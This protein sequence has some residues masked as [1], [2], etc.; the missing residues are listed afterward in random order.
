[1]LWL[2]AYLLPRIITSVMLLEVDEVWYQLPLASAPPPAPSP[3]YEG[4]DPDSCGWPCSGPPESS[5]H[6][7]YASR[8][9][10][11]RFLFVHR[12]P[13]SPYVMEGEDDRHR[14]LSRIFAPAKCLSC[15]ASRH[16]RAGVTE[17]PVIAPCSN[18][19]EK[20]RRA[21]MTLSQSPSDGWNLPR[22]VRTGERLG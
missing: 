6:D 22:E 10:S 2:T 21:G 14:L 3:L 13:V 19:G 7:V 15:I 4:F 16:G 17:M 1:M 20:G 18:L 11:W 9:P 12:Y 5:R 8:G